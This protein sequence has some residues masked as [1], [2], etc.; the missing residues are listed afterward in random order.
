MVDSATD[1]LDDLTELYPKPGRSRIEI[2]VPDPPER[3]EA[4]LRA[5]A[6]AELCYHIP[7]RQ[8][9]DLILTLDGRLRNAKA[10]VRLEFHHRQSSF[11]K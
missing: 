4:D 7:R 10:L 9:S 8:E 2:P 11:P 6:F 5:D 1:L 3:A